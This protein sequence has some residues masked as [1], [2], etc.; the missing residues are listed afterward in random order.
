LGSGRLSKRRG[1]Q[2]RCCDELDA[3]RVRSNGID[4]YIVVKSKKAEAYMRKTMEACRKFYKRRRKKDSSDRSWKHP[5]VL[6]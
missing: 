6:P 5:N 3:L 2:R 4:S 1:G